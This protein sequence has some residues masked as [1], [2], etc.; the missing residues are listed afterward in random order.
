MA[1]APKTRKQSDEQQR[2]RRLGQVYTPRAIA[3]WMV[4]AALQDRPQRWLDPALGGGIFIDA[5]HD[6]LAEDESARPTVRAFEIDH[7]IDIKPRKQWPD[8]DVRLAR[9]DFLTA[10][11]RMQF[12]ACVANPPYVR[13]HAL[14]YPP[15]VWQ[16]FDRQVGSR[17]SRNTNLYCLFM[18]RIWSLLAPQGRAVIITPL[19]W[20][21]ADFGRLLKAYLM[22]E[23]ALDALLLFDDASTVFGDALTTA[24]ITILRRDRK[25]NDAIRVATVSDGQSVASVTSSDFQTVRPCELD[26]DTKWTAVLRGLNENGDLGSKK[27]TRLETIAT[28]SRGVA[29]GAN[30]YFTLTEEQRCVHQIDARDVSPCVTR[31]N[32]LQAGVFDRKQWQRLRDAGKR[33]WLLTPR[34]TCN[35]R[36][37]AYLDLGRER[38]IDRRHLPSHRP[39][40]YH[41][42]KRAPAPILISVFFRERPRV[43]WNAMGALN[44][45]AY[46]GIYA[47]DGCESEQRLFKLYEWLASQSATAALMAQSRVYGGGLRKLEPRDVMAVQIPEHLVG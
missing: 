21:N 2:K 22:Q 28:C 26:P 34:R 10:R 39:I 40:W 9:R 29:T 44:L 18:L 20:L 19:E 45:T 38:G 15:D 35:N 41:P 3:D 43:V 7:R 14:S 37:A 25:P 11:M 42:E 23:N 31:A 30:D 47:K 1:T 24:G 32:D 46:H 6:A 36:L 33:V 13:H 17:I 27:A 16:S 8:I 4:G 12:D 5:L